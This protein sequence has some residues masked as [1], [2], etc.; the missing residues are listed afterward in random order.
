MAFLVFVKLVKIGL[1]VLGSGFGALVDFLLNSTLVVVLNS[2]EQHIL[3]E[4]QTHAEVADEEE[5]EPA[6]RIV[7]GQHHVGKVGRRKQHEHVKA[8]ERGGLKVD[9]PF[10]RGSE[11]EVSNEREEGYVAEDGEDQHR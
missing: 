10:E 9:V 8:R 4:V 11:C 5:A 6:V 2:R 3:K 7:R 1:Y